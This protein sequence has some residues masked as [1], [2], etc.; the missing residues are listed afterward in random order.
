M[1]AKRKKGNKLLTTVVALILIILAA[2]FK[3]EIKIDKTLTLEDGNL[4][5]YYVDVGQGHCTVIQSGN[6]G[7]IIDSGEREYS[8]T[9]LDFLD[10]KGITK[11]DYI[12]ATHYHSDHIG[13]LGAIITKTNPENLYMPYVIDEYLPTNKTYLNFLTAIDSSSV[14]ARL[15]KKITEFEFGGATF[16]IVPPPKQ[17]DSTNNM[18]LIT[19]IV[20]GDV[21]FLIAGDAERA[22]MKELLSKNSSFDFSADFFLMAHHGSSTSTYEPFLSK[23]NFS[24]AVI[25]CAKG[26]DYGHPHKEALTYL[27]SHSINYYRTD[28]V[29]TIS[30][31]TDSKSCNITTE[32][33]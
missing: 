8:Q 18:S 20:F 25:S 15:V 11:I 30:V 29:G 26:N 23:V 13:G 1:A 16:T 24:T 32:K 17:T 19:K 5:V 7:V 28:E 6:E 21:S 4:G 14:K 27:K 10:S 3:D 31:V 9:V 33:G 12:I 2:F 22:E